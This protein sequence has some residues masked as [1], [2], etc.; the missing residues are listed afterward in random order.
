MS[1][2]PIRRG[3]FVWTHF[4]T[5]ERPEEP[6][7]ERHIALCAREADDRSGG[8]ALL[9]IYTTTRPRGDRPK[10]RGEIEITEEKAREL[11]QTSAF[12]IDAKR[13]AAL[14]LTKE[15]FP[16][17]ARP[18]FGRRGHSLHLASAC[19]KMI[20]KIAEKTPELIEVLGPSHARKL[21]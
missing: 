14:P 15:F 10:A 20:G 13:I 19:D 17:I 4:P 16:D 5:T 2:P 21:F 6:S 12:R 1:L 3:D 9:A 18:G 7:K 11:G 8:Y